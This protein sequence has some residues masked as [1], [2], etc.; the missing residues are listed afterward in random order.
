M[1]EV[2]VTLCQSYA[3]NNFSISLA[4]GFAFGLVQGHVHAR[5]LALKGLNVSSW[6]K[7]NMRTKLR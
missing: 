6:N 5:H 1:G 2:K 3:P 4:C 7:R